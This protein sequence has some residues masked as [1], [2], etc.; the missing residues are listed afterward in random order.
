MTML[1]TTVSRTN[2]SVVSITRPKYGSVNS[3]LYWSKP[4]NVTGRA[5]QVVRVE[6]QIERVAER[7]E[8]ERREHGSRRC[9]AQQRDPALACLAPAA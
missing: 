5:E 6:A 9:E 1:G 7:V 2:H 3:R 8:H 4:T